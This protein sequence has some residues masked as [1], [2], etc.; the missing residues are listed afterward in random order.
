MTED[1]Q[2]KE[3][4]PLAST[5]LKAHYLVPQIVEWQIHK[6]HHLFKDTQKQERQAVMD[7][8]GWPYR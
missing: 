8:L 4:D 7:L 1:P 5:L 3:L 6:A 2:L